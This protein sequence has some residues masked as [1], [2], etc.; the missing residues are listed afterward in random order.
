MV[1][2][3]RVNE[4]KTDV[5]GDD[6][7]EMIEVFLEEVEG[8]LKR[9]KASPAFSTFEEDFHF[10]KGCALNVGFSEFGRLCQEAESLAAKGQAMSVEIDQI[11]DAYSISVANLRERWDEIGLAA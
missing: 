5:F 2:W 9:L 4:L 8:V 3:D 10:L 11:C 6:F 1:D 7:A